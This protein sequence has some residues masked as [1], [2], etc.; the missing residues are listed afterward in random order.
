MVPVTLDVNIWEAV[1]LPLQIVWL[2]GDTDIIGVG[3]TF[4][5][6][7]F[8]APAHPPKVGVTVNIPVACV[9]PVFVAVNDVMTEP[10]P[11]EPIPIVV[12]LFAQV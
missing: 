12:L 3:F 8:T 10:L 11:V 9:V 1:L 5:V 2:V 7:V 6:N 4:I